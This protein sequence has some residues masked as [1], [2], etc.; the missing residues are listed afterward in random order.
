MVSSAVETMLEA[1]ETSMIDHFMDLQI[2]KDME[3][4]PTTDTAG[5]DPCTMTITTMYSQEIT[6]T[7]TTTE[8][9]GD[10]TTGGDVLEWQPISFLRQVHNAWSIMAAGGNKKLVCEVV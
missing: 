5:R 3:E 4:C 1:T 2:T 6:T 9:M 7:R 10:T 8:A